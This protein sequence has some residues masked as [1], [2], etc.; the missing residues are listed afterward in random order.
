[1]KAIEDRLKYY[2]MIQND[3][4]SDLFNTIASNPEMSTKFKG[5]HEDN[6]E[7]VD[8]TKRQ[9]TDIKE[10]VSIKGGYKLEINIG[11]IDP[12]TPRELQPMKAGEA[13]EADHPS[14]RALQSRGRPRPEDEE[15]ARGPPEGV[16]TGCGTA[17]AVRRDGATVRAGIDVDSSEIVYKVR[18]NKLLYFDERVVSKP[19]DRRCLP[20]ER[21]HV[22]VPT[23]KEGLIVGWVSGKTTTINY[24]VYYKYFSK[25]QSLV[26]PK[27]IHTLF[28]RL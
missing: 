3:G 6:S 1:M 16:P 11:G 26:G 21:L 8:V 19:T 24:F 23:P 25:I 27:M 12:L 5:L 7:I 15:A 18:Q 14:Q 28:S 22:Y 4:I 20:V 10:E 9:T 13:A 17:R 2:K